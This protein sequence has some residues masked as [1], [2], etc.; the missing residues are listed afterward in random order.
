MS[1]LFFPASSIIHK[2]KSF[3]QL[4]QN[5]KALQIKSSDLTPKLGHMYI[6]WQS[7]TPSS[8]FLI[9]QFKQIKPKRTLPS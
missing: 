3:N 5:I 8:K 7:S 4:L 6:G 9:C 1:L 2:S